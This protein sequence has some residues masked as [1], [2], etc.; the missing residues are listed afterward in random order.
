MSLLKASG[1]FRL[2]PTLIAIIVSIV[3]LTMHV[4]DL[5]ACLLQGLDALFRTQNA[6]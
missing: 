3:H 2:S 1:K 6:I 5:K 4:H